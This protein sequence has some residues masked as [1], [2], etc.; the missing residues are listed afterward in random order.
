METHDPSLFELVQ[1]SVDG[2]LYYAFKWWDEQELGGRSVRYVAK[3]P[4]CD[5]ISYMLIICANRIPCGTGLVAVKFYEVAGPD[6]SGYWPAETTWGNG[7]ADI[8]SVVRICMPKTTFQAYRGLPGDLEQM[9]REHKAGKRHVQPPAGKKGTPLDAIHAVCADVL[10]LKR[11][12][13]PLPSAVALLGKG[14]E[15][16]RLNIESIAKNE[17]ELR[18]ENAEL[19]R[20]QAEGYLKFAAKINGG[21]FAAF[22]YIMA[23]GNRKKAADSL[24]VP[25][26]TFYDK[27]DNWRNQGPEY[28]RMLRLVEWRK[29]VGRQLKVRLEDSLLSGEPNGRAE[30]PETIRDVL[31][32]MKDQEVD[33]RDYPAIL[34]EILEALSIQ[35][36]ANWRAVNKE[37]VGIITEELPQ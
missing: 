2:G 4:S 10:D 23:M 32:R 25:F 15:T 7:D 8:E 16:M 21:D 11:S 35:N 17:Y 1:I 34:R 37:V 36:P 18:Q 28:R 24:G 19:Q 6:E 31:T 30:N 33:S 29:N 14:V 3:D 22:I 13:S 20:L 27:V 9:I 26:R 12:M 5:V